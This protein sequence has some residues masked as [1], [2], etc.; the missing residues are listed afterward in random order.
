MQ[1]L[2]IPLNLEIFQNLVLSYRIDRNE[3]FLEFS[4]RVF[5]H[6]KLC[7]RL[8][9]PDERESYVELHR[10]SILKNSLP[11]DTLN[12]I[13]KKEQ[14]Y[15]AFSSQEILDHV[16]S[17]YHLAGAEN[18]SEQY[19]VFFTQKNTAEIPAAAQIRTLEENN[20]VRR[21]PGGSSATVDKTDK[22]KRDMDPPARQRGNR[23]NYKN[24]R[25]RGVAHPKQSV[26]RDHQPQL[27]RDGQADMRRDVQAP[28]NTR[29]TTLADVP[30][31]TCVKCLSSNHL[32]SACTVY[33]H[34]AICR[35]LCTVNAQP[36][37][38]HHR[39]DC[40]VKRNLTDNRGQRPRA[41][42]YQN[43]NRSSRVF[44]PFR[45]QK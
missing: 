15:R 1:F 21:K 26:R 27:R 43:K 35:G 8:K 2:Y 29:F 22:L 42:F 16:I 12:V 34:A 25:S 20:E 44:R 19:H 13:T 6:L 14:I 41:N 17:S 18:E 45:I 31:G 30:R 38:F 33:P 37:G 24:A 40:V 7:S 28:T 9:S 23:G 3:S 5:R 39:Q 10:C 32:T 36:H 11:S 4:S